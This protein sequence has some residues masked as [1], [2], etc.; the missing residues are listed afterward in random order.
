M[1]ETEVS[2]YLS[3]LATEHRVAAST[4]N[5]ALAA[6]VFLYAEV[7]EMPFG[8]L[9]GLVRAKKPRRQPTVM[10]RDEAARVRRVLTGAPRLIALLMYGSGLRLMEACRLRVKD[11]DLGGRALIVRHGKGG[12]DR[13]TML[14]D[15]AASELMPHLAPRTEPGGPASPGGYCHGISGP[16]RAER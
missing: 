11:V 13:L 16:S 3:Y 9:S 6:L 7:F 14:A 2:R 1:G 15:S 12:R 8:W 10:T 4:Q 5:Q